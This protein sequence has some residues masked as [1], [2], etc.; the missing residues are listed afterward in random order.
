VLGLAIGKFGYDPYHQLEVNGYSTADDEV[1][2]G[3][4]FR[5]AKGNVAT[6]YLR[7]AKINPDGTISHPI[8][9]PY[10]PPNS[11]WWVTPEASFDAPPDT[12]I[13]GFG[14]REKDSNL[15]TLVVHTRRLDAQTGRLVDPWTYRVGSEPDHVLEAEGYPSLIGWPEDRTV[16]RGLGLRADSKAITTLV[17][18]WG[19]IAPR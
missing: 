16:M 18:Y 10:Y 13:V 14:V 6:M 15:T 7:F 1:L 17:C 8:D 5:L 2:V 9:P 19:V 12:V 4:G 11:E 3:M